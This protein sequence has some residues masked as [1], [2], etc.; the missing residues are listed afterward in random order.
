MERSAIA[1][2]PGEHEPNR[3]FRDLA[4]KTLRSYAGLYRR[5]AQKADGQAFSA[6]EPNALAA[7]VV[8]RASA[9][10]PRDF[11]GTQTIDVMRGLTRSLLAAGHSAATDITGLAWSEA[12]GI[13]PL[14]TPPLETL[15]AI[16][17]SGAQAGAISGLHGAAWR[18]LF[19][20][21]AVPL[22]HAGTRPLAAEQLDRWVD[23]I[24]PRLGEMGRKH[25]AGSASE[26]SQRARIATVTAELAQRL[27]DAALMR[28]AITLV[29]PL[30]R[31]PSD[32]RI[33]VIDGV[34]LPTGRAAQLS[35]AAESV[36]EHRTAHDILDGLLVER[37]DHQRSLFRV[38][39][40]DDQRIETSPWVPLAVAS[41]VG[42]SPAEAHLTGS[43][44]RRALA[45]ARRR[46]T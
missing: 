33:P 7:L 38:S 21:S 43:R 27:A 5:R 40:G 16:V 9:A 2:R 37:F 44:L 42:G 23:Y 6:P 34:A 35:V 14:E 1:G 17:V 30:L 39:D 22:L 8:Q 15:D 19:L 24:R 41:L 3:V 25:H 31:R 29:K 46:S 12:Y 20:A 45:R 36:G 4:P 11:D 28:G 32:S 26:L 10:R 13:L 18:A